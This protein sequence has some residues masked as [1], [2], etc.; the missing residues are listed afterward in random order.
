MHAYGRAS[1]GRERRHGDQHRRQ[2]CKNTDNAPQSPHNH[3][4]AHLVQKFSIQTT[5]EATRAP[6]PPRSHR[7]LAKCRRTR[8]VASTQRLAG[9]ACCNSPVRLA[10]ERVRSHISA[11]RGLVGVPPSRQR[12]GLVGDGAGSG[13]AIRNGISV[14]HR[15]ALWPQRRRVAGR[16]ADGLPPTIPPARFRSHCRAQAVSC[17]RAQAGPHGAT[18]AQ[19]PP[20]TN[21]TNGTNGTVGRRAHGPP[22]TTGTGGQGQFRQLDVTPWIRTSDHP[23]RRGAARASS[24]LP[25]GEPSPAREAQRLSE[26]AR[27]PARDEQQASASRLDPR[28][29]T[30]KSSTG[31]S[32]STASNA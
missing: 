28:P 32:E 24:K 16:V 5:D 29:L 12:T 21:G 9:G 2:G 26:R 14:H 25:Y 20:G 11:E 7:L 10:P 18:G 22:R 1:G 17:R 3:L 27:T 23:T 6:E 19:G 31:A 4:N 30:G 15:C 13:S 8:R